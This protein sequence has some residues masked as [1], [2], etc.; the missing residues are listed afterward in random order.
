MIIKH[1][2]QPEYLKAILLSLGV[3]LS[4][5]CKDE[6][7]CYLLHPINS[8]SKIELFSFQLIQIFLKVCIRHLIVVLKLAVL[9][10]LLLDGIVGE[11][12]E[13]IL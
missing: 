8:I 10:S 4:C 11:V 3:Q 7:S 13:L 12:Y 9:F 1:E 6:V 2:V 5:S